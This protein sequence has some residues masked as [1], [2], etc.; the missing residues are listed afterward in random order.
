MPTTAQRQTSRPTGR[1]ILAIGLLAGTL[2]VA[3][4]LVIR[5]LVLLLLDEPDVPYPL[6]LPPVVEFTFLPSLLGTLLFLVL[7]RRTTRPVRWFTIAAAAV[8]VL[9][10][11]APLVLFPRDE[12]T[13]G[14]LLALLVMHM[15]PAVV[16][17]AAPRNAAGTA[18]QPT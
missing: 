4:N 6:V 12:I 3:V 5:A 7:R 8:V 16:L 13:V 1:R 14:V 18:A 17:V 15:T 2:S 10:W 11:A 9:S